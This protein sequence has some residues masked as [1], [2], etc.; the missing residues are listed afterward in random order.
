[1]ADLEGH[2][3]ASARGQ[4]SLLVSRFA[5]RVGQPL[6]QQVG[7]HGQAGSGF[8]GLWYFKLRMIKGSDSAIDDCVE[9]VTMW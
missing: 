9:F 2:D 1:M 7:P 5:W 6:S 4:T 8:V 3:P